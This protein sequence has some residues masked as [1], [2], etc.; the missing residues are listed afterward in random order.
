MV[1]TE[2][3]CSSHSN[4]CDG[5]NKDVDDDHVVKTMYQ[6]FEVTLVCSMCF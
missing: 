1:T 4:N 6:E 5:A 2:Y 3:V